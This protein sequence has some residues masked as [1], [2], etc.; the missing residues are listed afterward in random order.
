MASALYTDEN[1]LDVNVQG[2]VI[3]VDIGSGKVMTSIQRAIAAHEPTFQ[4]TVRAKI[5]NGMLTNRRATTM[6]V[7][8]D[9]TKITGGPRITW[10][11]FPVSKDGVAFKVVDLIATMQGVLSNC[12]IFDIA[13]VAVPR[14][15]LEH[16][17][18]WQQDIWVNLFAKFGT[19]IELWLITDDDPVDDLQDETEDVDELTLEVAL[20]DEATAAVDK[21]DEEELTE[22]FVG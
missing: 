20:A 3:P 19:D 15:S 7:T 9:N 21:Y 12:R 22:M 17:A 5:A 16:T 2:Y 1:L 11:L 8:P 10:F 18:D 14:L 4:D 6:D 13:S